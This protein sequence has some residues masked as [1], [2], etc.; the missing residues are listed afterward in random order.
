MLERESEMIKVIGKTTK[1]IAQPPSNLRHTDVS[2]GKTKYQR[3]LVYPFLALFLQLVCSSCFISASVI[4]EASRLQLKIR[5]FLLG[6]MAN[7]Y[8]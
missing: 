4:L 8:G 2:F 6:M 5:T 3:V 7:E 1:D